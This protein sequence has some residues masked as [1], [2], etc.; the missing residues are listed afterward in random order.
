MILNF[1]KPIHEKH[2]KFITEIQ[3]AGSAYNN[4]KRRRGETGFALKIKA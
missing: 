4:K 3:S 2:I 1:F